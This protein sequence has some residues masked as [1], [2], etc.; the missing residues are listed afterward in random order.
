MGT[1]TRK[2]GQYCISV[3]GVR[4][5]ERTVS[6]V[7]LC[8][9][10]GLGKRDALPWHSRVQYFSLLTSLCLFHGYGVYQGFGGSTSSACSAVV[11]PG[12]GLR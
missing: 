7:W 3:C 1:S 10:V 9:S 4:E 2:E 11:Y 6:S 5:E 8:I 12:V